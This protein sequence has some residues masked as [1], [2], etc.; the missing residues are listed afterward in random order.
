MVDDVYVIEIVRH[1]FFC[2]I[3]ENE[4]IAFLHGQSYSNDIIRN[5]FVVFEVYTDLKHRNSG[6]ASTLYEYLYRTLGYDIL[7]DKEQTNAG[8]KLW[9]NLKSQYGSE[10]AIYDTETN[11]VLDYDDVPLENLY[12]NGSSNSKLSNRYRLLLTKNQHKP[13]IEGHG[14]PEMN[15]ENSVLNKPHR[16]YTAKELNWI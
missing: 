11:T 4:L 15:W 8:I 1:K 5:G 7:S 12:I 9:K 16:H 10:V 2:I 13:I 3:Q 14:L 6:H